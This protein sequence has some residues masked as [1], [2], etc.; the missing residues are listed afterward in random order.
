MEFLQVGRL[1]GVKTAVLDEEEMGALLQASLISPPC[2]LLSPEFVDV[3]ITWVIC[4][5]PLHALCQLLYL[6]VF[7]NL[8][9]YTLGLLPRV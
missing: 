5:H 3:Y 9:Q 4:P 6:N 8:N 1:T 2:L 7:V